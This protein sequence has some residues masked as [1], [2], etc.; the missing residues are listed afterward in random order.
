MKLTRR[1]QLYVLILLAAGTA[2]M[3]YVLQGAMASAHTVSVFPGWFWIAD[4]VLWGLRALIEAT[5]I[6]YLFSTKSQSKSQEALLVFFEVTLI[7]TIAMTIGPVFRA[8]GYGKSM[9]EVLGEPWYTIWCYLAAAYTPLMIGATGFAYRV[10]P[11]DDDPQVRQLEEELQLALRDGREMQA[12]LTAA[13]VELESAKSAISVLQAEREAFAD[14]RLLPV[15]ERV[16]LITNHGNGNVSQTA[17]AEVFGKT[18]G[19]I[20]RWVNEAR[21]GG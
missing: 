1:T 10:Q 12:G 2:A 16:R 6:M 9:V 11:G 3:Q 21:E 17:L 15:K 19:T 7:A 14:W 18:Q 13:L 8:L 5:V 20:S 4:F